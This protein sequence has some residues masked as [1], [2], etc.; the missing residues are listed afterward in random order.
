[1]QLLLSERLG[2]IWSE[3]KKGVLLTLTLLVE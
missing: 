1:M 3:K 2:Q